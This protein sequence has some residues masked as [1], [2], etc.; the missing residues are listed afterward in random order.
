MVFKFMKALD[1]TSVV[2]EGEQANAENSAGVPEAVR[3][4]YNKVMSGARLGDEQMKQF[5]FTAKSLANSAIDSSE[6][7]ITGFLDTFEGTIPKGFRD[8]LLK[9]IPARFDVKKVPKDVAKKNTDEL[10]DEELASLYGGDQ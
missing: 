10:S 8:S 7:E 6:A 5:V 4:M 3:N 9:R 2:R 1:P